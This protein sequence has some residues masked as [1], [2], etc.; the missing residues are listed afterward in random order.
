[1]LRVV[2]LSI[3]FSSLEK[4]R[5]FRNYLIENKKELIRFIF[6]KYK[7]NQVLISNPAIIRTLMSKASKQRNIKVL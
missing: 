4:S 3:R 2:I 6:N 7:E 5:L 1:M